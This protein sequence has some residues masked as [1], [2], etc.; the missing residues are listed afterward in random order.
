[1]T[2]HSHALRDYADSVT[3]LSSTVTDIPLPSHSPSDHENRLESRLLQPPHPDAW[4][5][6]KAEVAS[7]NRWQE[8]SLT[9]SS[10]ITSR[11][12]TPHP[13]S[14]K[15]TKI[16]IR[17]RRPTLPKGWEYEADVAEGGGGGGKAEGRAPSPSAQP[18]IPQP[19]PP[20]LMGGGPPDSRAHPY[21]T[22][23]R[24]RL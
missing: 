2:D 10:N 15:T 8:I 20:R 16:P 19:F 24:N 13:L 7:P 22:R 23:S 18:K 21:K 3:D 6:L 5:R 9:Q 17:F 11:W 4:S 14:G 1:M 12:K